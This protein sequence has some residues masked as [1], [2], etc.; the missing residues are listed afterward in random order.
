MENYKD[1]ELQRWRFLKDGELQRWRIT[2]MEILKLFI[3]I[4]LKLFIKIFFISKTLKL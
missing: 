2:K 3:K 1:G 4:I